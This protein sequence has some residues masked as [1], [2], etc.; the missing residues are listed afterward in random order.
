MS[1]IVGIL[2][3]LNYCYTELNVNNFQGDEASVYQARNF[4]LSNL[5]E[6]FLKQ[7]RFAAKSHSFSL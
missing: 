2:L 7:C 3:T 6:E 5:V 1:F 4:A